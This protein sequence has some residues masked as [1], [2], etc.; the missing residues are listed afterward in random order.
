MSEEWKLVLDESC[1]H[2]F[3]SEKVSQR[4]ILLQIFDRLKANPSQPVDFWER[5]DVGRPIRTKALSPFL[6]SYWL[7]DSVKEIRILEIERVNC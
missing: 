6:I 4:K 7:D 3:L 1:L 2:F 5:D